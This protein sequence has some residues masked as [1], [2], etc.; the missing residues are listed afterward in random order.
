MKKNIDQ[1]L[2]F[3]V[4]TDL[5]TLIDYE[6]TDISFLPFD[7]AA[8]LT[9]LAGL[10]QASFLPTTREGNVFRSICDSVHGGGGWSAY[11]GR[12]CLLGRFTYLGWGLPAKG[13]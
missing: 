12:V 7:L 8:Y 11:W 2:T 4:V 10:Y 9:C 1:N 6:M 13:V 3:S 5:I